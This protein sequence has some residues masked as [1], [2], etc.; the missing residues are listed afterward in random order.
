M[1]G[2]PPPETHINAAWKTGF[3]FGFQLKIPLAKKFLLQT[4]YIFSERS[5]E[6][7]SISTAYTFDYLSLPVLLNYRLAK[8]FNL[9]AGPQFEILISAGSSINGIQTNITHDVEERGIGSSAD[10]SM[11][12]HI[13]SFSPHDI[14]RDSITWESDNVP[15]QKNS[16]TS[17]PASLRVSGS[18]L[19]II[20]LTT[21]TKIPP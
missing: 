12:S 7:H 4:E 9:I 20:R 6:D 10:W 11:P 15:I 5:G 19:P 16:S 1:Q 13:L 3:T 18:D 17:S 8:R 2:E 14:S 21:S